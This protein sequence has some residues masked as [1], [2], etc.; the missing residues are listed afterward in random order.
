MIQ[1]KVLSIIKTCR[2]EDQL[3]TCLKWVNTIL[4]YKNIAA[5][6]NTKDLLKQFVIWKPAK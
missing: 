2:T 1:E 5:Q 6:L 3:D 4:K